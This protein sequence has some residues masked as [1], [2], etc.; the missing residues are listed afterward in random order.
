MVSLYNPGFAHVGEHFHRG[1]VVVGE[2]QALAL[3]QLADGRHV[4]AAQGEVKHTD[5]L[6]HTLLVGGL[7][8]HHHAG[9][10]QEAQGGLGGGLVVLGA[11]LGQHGVVEEV[12]PAL[13]EGAPALMLY[14]V[15]LHDFMGLGLLLEHMGLHLVDRRNHLP[16]RKL[17]LKS[18]QT[19]Y[20]S[21]VSGKQGFPGISAASRTL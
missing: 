10:E 4:L 11:D 15:L 7:G 19:L 18:L 16:A 3:V 6:L 1:W 12:L 13:G 9:L 20:G 5:V 21:L 2:E 8:D 14:A 17:S